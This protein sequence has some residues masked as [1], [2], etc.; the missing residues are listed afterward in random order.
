MPR[1]EIEIRTT[2]EQVPSRG[3]KPWLAALAKRQKNTA[4]MEQALTC[5]RG[6]V[7]VYQQSKESYW[8]PIAQRRVTEMEAELVELQR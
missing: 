8:L 2:L 1:A 4:R 7:E 6:A 3:E 5:M